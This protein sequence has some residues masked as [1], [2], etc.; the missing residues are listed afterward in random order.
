M[1][2]Y[3]RQEMKLRLAEL[4][5]QQ[6]SHYD[7]QLTQ[8]FLK[9]PQYQK[10]QTLALFL[11]MPAEVDTTEILQQALRDGK[12][13]LVPKTYSQGQMA[14]IPYEADRLHLSAFGVWEPVGDEAVSKEAIDL[15]L[16]PGLAWNPQG[17]RI[18]YGGGFY[19]RYLKDYKGPTISLAYAFQYQE[20]KAEPHDVPVQEVYYAR[21]L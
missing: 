13:V 5:N 7:K 1:K 12:Q 17:Y 19:D 10:S 3:L 20:F 11:S 6:K 9:S 15:I 18:G 16:V 2:K 21:N 4:S 8:D 14:F